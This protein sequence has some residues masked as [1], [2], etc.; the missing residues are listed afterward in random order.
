MTNEEAIKELENIKGAVSAVYAFTV[1]EKK[2]AID[3]A[4]KALKKP[5]GHW[6]IRKGSPDITAPTGKYYEC[7]ECGFVTAYG[8][9]RYCMKCGAEMEKGVEP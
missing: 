8:S 3:M 7:S 1:D 9:P 2:E 4:I 6:I 5:A